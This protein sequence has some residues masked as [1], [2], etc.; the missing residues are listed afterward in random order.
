MRGNS[1]TYTRNDPDGGMTNKQW[2]KRD[3]FLQGRDDQ[4][5]ARGTERARAD[6]V[7]QARPRPSTVV[8]PTRTRRP[9]STG[10]RTA[11]ERPRR[12]QPRETTRPR[13]RSQ[14]CCL[15][16]TASITS[17]VTSPPLNCT[18]SVSC[19][20]HYQPLHSVTIVAVEISSL[21]QS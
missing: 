11:A 13:H 19:T 14:S 15:A 10:R 3:H 17:F 9:R 12:Q 18:R 1:R 16:K 6:H 8:G 5:R 21:C 7:F 2:C 20:L 4:Q